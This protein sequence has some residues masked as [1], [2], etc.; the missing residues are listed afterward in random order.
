MDPNKANSKENVKKESDKNLVDIA[1][2]LI[3]FIPLQ[4]C[5]NRQDVSNT[6]LYLASELSSYVTG[7]SILVDGGCLAISPNWLPY[8]PQFL[9]KWTSKF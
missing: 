5:G 4:R 1:N 7:Q 8:Y 9:S 6:I 2:K 3:S